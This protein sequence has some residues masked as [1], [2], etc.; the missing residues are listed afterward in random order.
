[1]GRGFVV[2][3]RRFF[4]GWVWRLRP[5]QRCVFLWLVYRARWGDGVDQIVLPEQVIEVD[6]GQ[7]WTTLRRVA[8]EC[9]V[10]L[11]VVRTALKLF[12]REGAISTQKVGRYGTLITVTKYET[13]QDVPDR[14]NTPPNTRPTHGQHN[15]NQGNQGNQGTLLARPKRTR[16]VWSD[17]FKSVRAVYPQARELKQAWILWQKMKLEPIAPKIRAWVVA[18]ER[19]RMEW[20]NQG[21]PESEPFMAHLPYMHRFLKREY[22]TEPVR[23]QARR[24]ERDAKQEDEPNVLVE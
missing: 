14:P 13:Y 1:M 2:L 5:E 7:V 6:R 12:E 11:Q 18:Y 8:D 4:E 15:K 23:R 3:A 19:A 22:W 9:G 10:G 24:I 17:G 16:D 20:I 21:R